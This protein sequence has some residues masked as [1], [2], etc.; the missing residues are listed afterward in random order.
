MKPLSNA[1]KKMLNGL[2]YADAGEYL[3][4]RQKSAYLENV[5][6]TVEDNPGPAP[7]PAPSKPV[8]R[9][10]AN[11]RVAMYLGSELPPAVMDYV[12]DTCASLEHDL[13]VLTFESGMVSSALLNPYSERLQ[14]KGIDMEIA[15]LSG[16]PIKGLARYLRSH[17]EI[18]FL[19]CKDSGYLGRN[20]VNGTQLKS[21]LPVPVVVVVTDTAAAE[22]GRAAQTDNT[23]RI[24]AA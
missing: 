8:A 11:R 17:P 19:A 12:I 7:A 21:A 20:Y 15:R 13:S 14:A 9:T 10:S 18:A 3:S 5:N 6:Q 22:S 24:G 4:R 1:L 16:E 2:A 23:A